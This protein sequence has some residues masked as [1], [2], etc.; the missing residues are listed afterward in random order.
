M[1]RDRVAH[2]PIEALL[3]DFGNVVVPVDFGRMTSAWAAAAGRDPAEVAQR[4]AFDEPYCAYERGEIALGDYFGHLRR[5]LGV[6]LPD[7]ELLAGW[8]AIFLEPEPAME[9][10]LAE[11]SRRYPL[12]LFS[13]TNPEH[14]AH[15]APRYAAMLGYFTAVFTSCGIGARKPEAEAFRHVA[16]AIGADPARIVFFDDLAENV[17][18]AWRAG[19]Q[20]FVATGAADIRHVLPC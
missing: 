13:N 12:Y 3:L 2:P 18:G 17:E 9:P 14:H 15:W 20:A 10:L 5:R 11:L 8:N 4:F 16:L 1:S 7:G 19:L 6:D